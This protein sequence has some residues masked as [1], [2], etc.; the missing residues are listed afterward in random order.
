MSYKDRQRHLSKDYEIKVKRF[1]RLSFSGCKMLGNIDKKLWE[2]VFRRWF[3]QT[4][5]QAQ[6]I[7]RESREFVQQKSEHATLFQLCSN[8]KP[9]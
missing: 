2:I 8:T 4:E 1:I 7:L 3:M 5:F 9:A 6:R